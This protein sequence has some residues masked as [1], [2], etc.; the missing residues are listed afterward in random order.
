MLEIFKKKTPLVEEPKS[1]QPEVLEVGKQI[2]FKDPK[3]SE[4]VYQIALSPAQR[5]EMMVA[6]Q[7]NGQLAQQFLSA[8]RN[9]LIFIEQ[10]MIANK[11]ISESEKEINTIKTK[12]RDDLKLD[13]RWDFNFNLGVMERREPPNG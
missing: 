2:T 4:H 8:S 11:N 7:K 5:Q 13:P 9:F 12:F 3:T 6:M 1:P 10:A